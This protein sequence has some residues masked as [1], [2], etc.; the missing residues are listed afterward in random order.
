MLWTLRD[1]KVIDSFLGRFRQHIGLDV[2]WTLAAWKK[3]RH[4]LKIDMTTTPS[5]LGLMKRSSAFPFG[6]QHLNVLN[7]WDGTDRLS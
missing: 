7:R 6:A 1:T 4:A 5:V 2:D 3:A